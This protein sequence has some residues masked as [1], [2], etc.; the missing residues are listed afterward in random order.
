MK[1]DT[2]TTLFGNTHKKRGE[3][4][5]DA[6]GSSK[7][8]KEQNQKLMFNRITDAIKDEGD[9]SKKGSFVGRLS[10]MSQDSKQ[11]IKTII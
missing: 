1:S 10:K 4:E 7:T 9:F 3:V 5:N 2:K 8:N 6:I 11:P